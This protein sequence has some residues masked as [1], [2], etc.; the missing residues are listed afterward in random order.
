MAVLTPAHIETLRT[1]LWFGQ[2][3][4]A[5]ADELLARAQLKT[6]AAGQ[7]LF[8]RGD[9]PDGLY[10]VL[11]GTLRV[12]GMTEAGKEAVLSLIDPPTWLGEIALFDRLPRTHNVS[13]ETEAR[14]LH[15]RLVD[16]DQILQE[17]PAHW[18]HFGVLMA[19]KTR[20]VFIGLEDLSLLPPEGRLAR[21]LVWMVQ[22]AGRHQGTTRLSVSQA[23]LALMLS[24]SRQTANRAVM[25]L[26]SQGIVRVSYGVIEVLDA[27]ALADVARLSAMERKVLV[28]LL[29]AAAKPGS[30]VS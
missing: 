27:A 10:A 29:G 1:D 21:R 25:A 3:P 6:L 26:Q 7:H 5:L 18:Q 12:S 30:D 11:S 13:A 20:L 19:L 16:I 8:F 14:V 24:M 23:N 22:S 28:H 15:V 17:S 2:L 9:P 4:P